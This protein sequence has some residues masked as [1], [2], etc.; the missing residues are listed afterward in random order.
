MTLTEVDNFPLCDEDFDYCDKGEPY[1]DCSECPLKVGP[2]KD[3]LDNL[4]IGMFKAMEG[5][6]L[7]EM[8]L[9][10]L[11]DIS[12]ADSRRIVIVQS[13]TQKYRKIA[14]QIDSKN[15]KTNKS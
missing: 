2:V 10:K 9:L 14:Q 3:T 11:E 13:A 15:S 5:A 7:L 1:K 8:G 12:Y 4:P 6:A